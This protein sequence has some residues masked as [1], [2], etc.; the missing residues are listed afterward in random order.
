MRAI[1]KKNTAA[2]L[3]GAFMLFQLCVLGLG[4]HAG[5]GIIESDK[6]ELVYYGFQVLVIA[7]FLGYAA[8]ERLLRGERPRKYLTL[9][10]S[11]VLLAGTC[12]MGLADKGSLFYVGVTFAVMPCLGCLGG[13]VY[14]RMSRETAGGH[15]ARSMG[16]GCAAAVMMQYLLQI[17]WGETFLLP[18][19]V[20]LSLLAVVLLLR[21][22]PEPPP[23]E[24]PVGT[25][26]RALIFACLTAAALILFTSFY[27]GYI[28]HLQIQTGYT[29]YNVYS[30]P[31]LMLIPCY[32][33]FAL[34]GDRR[35]GRLVP[36]AA[37]CIAL[38]GMLNSVLAGS[39]G[40]Y[41]LNMC[42]FYCAIAAS[43]AYY[44]LTFWR[45]AQ[46]TKH[47]ALWAPMGR[48]LDSLVVL[49]TGGLHI[50]EFSPAMTLA[51][52]MFG[53]AVLIVIMSV[54]GALNL[55]SSP[56]DTPAPVSEDTAFERL[57]DQF[58]LTPRETDV[59]RELVLTED[60]QT[61]ISE[62]LSISVRMMQKYV[63]SLY[64]KTGTETRSGLAEL[65]R[66]AL[67]GKWQ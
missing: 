28:H 67:L 41:Q 11:A 31:R 22:E 59:L 51:M 19:A 44:N 54:S 8:C 33:L 63:T 18:V 38:A 64:K 3:F 62:R 60:K 30:R 29:S 58:A 5:E 17:H 15:T 42:L 6:R 48:I 27:N 40:T 14:H 45:L 21:T 32:L 39:S 50:S 9:A 61:A 47:P 57:R 43:V 34:I 16:I 26:P 46:G 65:Y 1:L 7:G 66:K 52:N 49:I 2:A 23:R 37:L 13:E 56:E 35:Q 25:A 4:N 53:L 24:I 20:P 36:I 10:L 12:I 55:K